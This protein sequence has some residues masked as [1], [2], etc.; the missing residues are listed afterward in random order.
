MQND[1]RNGFHIPGKF[2]PRTN[3]THLGRFLHEQWQHEQLEDKEIRRNPKPSV[4][5]IGILCKTG[6]VGK[7]EKQAKT[8]S[9]KEFA[10]WGPGL[11][12]RVLL[13]TLIAASNSAVS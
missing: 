1:F 7:E 9:R 13:R 2:I 5:S 4:Q 11:Q 10:S 6:R 8:K 3:H 12:T